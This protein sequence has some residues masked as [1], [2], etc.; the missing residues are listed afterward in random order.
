MK[1]FP[2]KVRKYA[3]IIKREEKVQV[4]CHYKPLEEEPMVACDGCEE[5]F[6][7]ECEHIPKQVW[8]IDNLSWFCENCTK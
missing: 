3:E 7:K 1:H 2:S 6:H 4:F 8:T 5:W